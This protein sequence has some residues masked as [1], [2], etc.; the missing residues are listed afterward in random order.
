MLGPA[1]GQSVFLSPGEVPWLD[2]EDV[3]EYQD[4]SAL[5]KHQLECRLKYIWF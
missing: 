3:Q 1:P 5:T 4:S 2:E